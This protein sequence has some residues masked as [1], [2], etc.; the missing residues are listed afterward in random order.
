MFIRSPTLMQLISSRLKAFVLLS[1]A[2]EVLATLPVKM[3]VLLH[4]SL[5]NRALCELIIVAD[6]WGDN[7]QCT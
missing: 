5:D 6:F 4:G 3:I 7:G 1:A 2:A